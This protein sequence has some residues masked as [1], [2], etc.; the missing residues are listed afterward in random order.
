VWLTRV[1]R[2]NRDA[3]IGVAAFVAAAL[4]ALAL[5]GSGFFSNRVLGMAEIACAS[6]L[7]RAKS[8]LSRSM[9]ARS[10]LWRNGHGRAVTMQPLSPSWTGLARRRSHSMSIFQRDRR[11][12][13]TLSL[14]RLSP[15]SISQRFFQLFVK[16]TKLEP[17]K[18]SPKHCR[19]R[20]FASTPSSRQ[21]TSHRLL[22]G[23]SRSIRTAR[24]PTA[25][26]APR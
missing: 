26:P 23:A 9:V 7:R 24:P 10:K 14:H 20:N 6:R 25:P 15:A 22:T 16:S 1:S 18:Q 11:P 12:M 4:V 13:R 21:L 5:V 2:E 17:T 19:S 3:Q 8:P